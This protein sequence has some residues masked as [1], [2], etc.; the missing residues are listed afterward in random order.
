MQHRH[1][2]IGA[3]PLGVAIDQLVEHEVA[4]DQ[5]AEGLPGV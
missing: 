1:R 2:R 3:Q 4:E 5:G